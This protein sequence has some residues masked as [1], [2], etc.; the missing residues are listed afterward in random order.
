MVHYWTEINASKFWRSKGHGD[1]KYAGNSSYVNRG[2]HY[3]THRVEV[4]YFVVFKNPVQWDF[5]TEHY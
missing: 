1:V 4:T 2:M 5:A 3:S